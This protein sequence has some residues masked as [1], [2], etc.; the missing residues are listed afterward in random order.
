M[1]HAGSKAVDEHLKNQVLQVTSLTVFD[2]S[3]TPVRVVE[4]T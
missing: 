1:P 2:R 3:S 4:A